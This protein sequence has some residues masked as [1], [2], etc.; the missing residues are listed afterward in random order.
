MA[1]P[2]SEAVVDVSSLYASIETLVKGAHGEA[3][4]RLGETFSVAAAPD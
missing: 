2:P 1:S 4:H 3:N